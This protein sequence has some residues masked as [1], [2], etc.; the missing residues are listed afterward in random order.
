MSTEPYLDKEED[1]SYFESLQTVKTLG[2]GSYGS[3]ILTN[4]NTALKTISRETLS[5]A[6]FVGEVKLLDSMKHPNI[7]TVIS[8]G[9]DDENFYL[10][11]P[12]GGLS[13]YYMA[14]N[15]YIFPF[16]Q[17]MYQILEGVEYLNDVRGIIHGE[18]NS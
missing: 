14:Q 5:N 4:K 15:Q 1:A 17:V 13:L 16:K 2:K 11:L 12:Y 9:F 10:E 7:L 3:V 18:L 8:W 6:N